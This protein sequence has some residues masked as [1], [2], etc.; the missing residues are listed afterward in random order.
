MNDQEVAPVEQN[1]NG[2]Q[3]E[4]I[5]HGE[6][7]R[8]RRQQP[9]QNI[10]YQPQRQ[11]ENI[12]RPVVLPARDGPRSSSISLFISI[13][14]IVALVC[15]VAGFLGGRFH[16]NPHEIEKLYNELKLANNTCDIK[17]QAATEQNEQITS[18]EKIIEALQEELK[19]ETNKLHES[20]KREMQLTTEAKFKTVPLQITGEDCCENYTN[21]SNFI[22][23]LSIVLKANNITFP[24]DPDDV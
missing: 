9:Q 5:G 20:E 7:V 17:L 2:V 4:L 11:Q 6:Q 18:L 19:N 12:V 16:A 23:K 15:S 14:I 10:G 22:D 13:A 24:E 1:E 21:C 3:Q 8:Y